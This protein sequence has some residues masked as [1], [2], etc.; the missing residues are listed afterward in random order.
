MNV[1]SAIRNWFA[2]P[3]PAPE[4]DASARAQAPG[5]AVQKGS[6][7]PFNIAPPA[8]GGM[9][10]GEKVRM[11][12]SQSLWVHSAIK[13]IA[14]PISAV[15]LSISTDNPR[16][17]K[18][19]KRSS[20]KGAGPSGGPSGAA[21]PAGLADYFTN[22]AL[23]IDT[24]AQF[25][26][27]SVTWRKL[28]GEVFWILDDSALVPFP[29]VRPAYSRIILGRPDRMRHVVKDGII[30]GW[31][32]VD[33]SNKK[34]VL[35]PEQVVHLKQFNPYDDYRGLG[36]YEAARINVGIAVGNEKFLKSLADANGDQGVYIVAKNGIPDDA[37]RRQIIDQLREK[38]LMQQRGI[39]RPTFLA[40]DISIEDPKVRSTDADFTAMM[41]LVAEQIYIAF[42]VPPSMTKTAASYSIGS[43]S[44]YYR[45]ILDTCIPESQEL[46]AGMARVA[47]L[48]TRQTYY[49]SCDWDDHPVMQQVR[50]ERI[51]TFGKLCDRGMPPKFAGQYLN[52]ELPEYPGD[53]IGLVPIA[54]TPLDQATM[55]L[56]PTLGS[57]PIENE[58]PASGPINPDGDD[59]AG[60]QDPHGP[61][62]G[63][64]PVQVMLRVLRNGP[65]ARTKAD[66]RTWDRHMRKRKATMGQYQR[67]FSRVLFQARAETL[68]KI[69][70]R[71]HPAISPSSAD[72]SK[73]QQSSIAGQ[74][75]AQN[76][77]GRIAEGNPL[78]SDRSEI[79]MESK[80]GVNEVAGH[81]G[82]EVTQRSGA[83][84]YLFDL[85][86]FQKGFQASIRKVTMGALDTAGQDVFDEI[87]NEDDVFKFPPPAAIQFVQE[88]ANKLKDVPN[89]VFERIRTAIQDGM[90]AGDSVKDISDRIRAEYNDIDAG[91]GGTIAQTET[92]AAYGKARDTA[93]KQAGVE[94]K[95]WLTSGSANVRQAHRDANGQTVPAD[96]PFT[97]GG[98]ELDFPGD[99]R[100]SPG[101]VINCHCVSIPVAAPTSELD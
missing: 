46:A 38:R 61:E 33:G 78:P 98:E 71:Y 91:R 90:D 93:M 65:S 89:E 29:E 32:F 82:N 2:S 13:H 85:H 60:P 22:P 9:L 58:D 34:H 40:G 63:S 37:Q 14:G 75:P 24:Y 10:G 47:Q 41:G 5:E 79:R 88:R 35:L 4:A 45:L 66:K 59:S 83:I 62:D 25:I 23:G 67:A 16:A 100:G 87:G 42:G 57:E 44:D 50:S 77:P 76:A 12:M 56:D 7:F 36:E 48:L 74:D 69:A 8:D 27:A 54:V 15:P 92:A 3:A 52:L 49:I 51:D 30:T 21:S 19:A 55:P 97:V 43:A 68:R 6:L 18:G 1:F 73:N 99:T 94:Y 26:Q 96:Q 11:P 70:S 95:K 17:M 28:A 53:E 39:F 81:S 72:G 20:K 101:N 64:D 31:E 84:D 80:R 86:E